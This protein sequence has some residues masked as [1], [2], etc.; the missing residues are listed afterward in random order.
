[1]ALWEKINKIFG[2]NI[3]KEEAEI[4]DDIKRLAKERDNTKKIKDFKESDR[5]RRLIEEKGYLVE[6]TK[7]GYR[8]RKK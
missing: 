2:L 1:M 5:I 8:I 3:S 6:D 4:P 7:E